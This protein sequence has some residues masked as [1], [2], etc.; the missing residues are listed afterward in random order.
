MEWKLKK[1][2]KGQN[3]LSIY[4]KG[5]FEKFFRFNEILCINPEQESS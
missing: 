4:L 1:N 2:M 5:V 3:S